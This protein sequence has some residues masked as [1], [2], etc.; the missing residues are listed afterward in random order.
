MDTVTRKR[1]KAKICYK[2]FVYVKQKALTEGVIR[3]ECEKRRG[4]RKGSTECKAKLKMKDEVVVGSL[5]QHSH[6]PDEAR[7]EVLS[8]RVNIERRA[9]ETEK[10]PQQILGREM[11]NLNQA[12]AVQMVPER[13]IRRT[14]S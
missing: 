14:V 4:A 8:T 9:Q 7:S 1:G 12:A 10:H 3:F 13:F 5:H 6:A 2:G 11:E